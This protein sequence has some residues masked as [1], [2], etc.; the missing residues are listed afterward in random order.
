MEE[1]TPTGRSYQTRM[2]AVS[3]ALSLA[4][5]GVITLYL[6]AL[7]RMSSVEWTRFAS[8]VGVL[9][10]VL[11]VAQA[12][13]HDHLWRP[14]VR[15]LDARAAGQADATLLREGFA[16][17]VA[18]PLRT[19]TWGN[20]WW[21]AGGAL[22]AGAMAVVSESFRPFAGA[23]MVLAAGSGGFLMAVIHYCVM[24]RK[25]QPMAAK[26][27]EELGDPQLRGQLTP[28]VPLARKLGVSLAGITLVT[29]LF[30]GL[31]A[32][33]Q[34]ARP[35]EHR[36]VVHKSAFLE[37]LAQEQARGEESVLANASA[38]ASELKIAQQVVILDPTPDG[39]LAAALPGLSAAEREGIG[40]GGYESG[41]SESVDSNH[42]FSW[43]RLSDGRLAVAISD[44]RDVRGDASASW[45]AFGAFLAVV[46]ALTLV[47]TRLLAG[48]VA[49][50]TQLLSAEAERL[51]SGDLRALRPVT[52]E[53]EI[54]ELA[55]SFEAMAAGLRGMVSK[56]QWAAERVESGAEALAPISSGLSE[57]SSGARQGVSRATAGMQEIDAQVRGIATSSSS[58]NGSV[59]ESS[60][61]ILELGAA[62]AELKET[63]QILSRRVDEASSSMEQMVSSVR[64]VRENS[65][66]LAGAAEETSASMEEMASSLREVDVAASEA[67]RLSEGVVASAEKGQAQV[68]ETIAGM[69]QIQEAT[70][71]AEAVIRGL[72]GR[73]VEIGAIVDVIDDVADET[74]LLALN[75]AI[76][77]AQAGEHGRAFSVVAEEIKDLAER[78]LASTKEIGSLIA[79][80]Q[81][82]ARSATTAIEQG[83]SRVARGVEQ[84]AEAGLALEQITRSSKE[85]GRRIAGIVTA[86]QAQA[87]AAGHVVGLMERVRDGVHRIEQATAEQD[88]ASAVIS[89]GTS[90]MR[91]VSRQVKGTTE[92]QA[93]GAARIQESIEGVRQVVEQIDG[94]LQEQTAACTAVLRELSHV[95]ATTDSQDSATRTLDAVTRALREHAA[96][97]KQEVASLRV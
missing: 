35:L 81:E 23:V 93:R 46:L 70:E 94:A 26:L 66:S 62:G 5:V 40:A 87:K 85:S 31:L 95:Q 51:S 45:L 43:R 58:L 50:A 36:D 96:A 17:I 92:E 9:F 13:M 1:S 47:T 72:S 4:T 57:A 91:D 37:R 7:L 32:T 89:A 48:D 30:A 97:L 67:S 55:R 38:L 59:E 82:E 64:Q 15:C 68:R 27:A 83:T 80:V 34:A 28:R 20:L 77:A 8:I 44:W 6:V 41:D 49:S 22:V 19:F 60:S 86:V 42:V 65:Q 18:L 76:I 79:A 63:A 10:V 25:L 56:V 84:S 2:L 90:T 69:E 73:T 29:S 78:V 33:V 12:R 21:I 14:L 39:G 11:F 75:A 71:R 52:N 61:S 54:G 3:A 74:N 16:A 24:K 88:R 53:D